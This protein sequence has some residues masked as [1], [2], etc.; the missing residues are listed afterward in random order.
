[1]DLHGVCIGPANGAV[2]V[3]FNCA[4]SIQISRAYAKNENFFPLRQYPATMGSMPA[5]EVLDRRKAS[6]E[7]G[8]HCRKLSPCS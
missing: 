2:N 1:M 3:V 5:P 6:G 4:M 7:H 8:R